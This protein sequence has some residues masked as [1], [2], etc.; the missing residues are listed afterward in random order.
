MTKY[1]INTAISKTQHWNF[2]FEV[3]AESL[4]E[5]KAKLKEIGFNE[6][7]DTFKLID[8]EKYDEH[9]NE[10]YFDVL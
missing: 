3:E 4:K 9:W 10:Q 8:E 1:L 7:L 5:A 6:S 2:T